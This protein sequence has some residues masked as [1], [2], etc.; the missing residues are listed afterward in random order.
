MVMLEAMSK[1][2][3]VVSFD[4]PTGP[5]EVIDHGEN[6]MLVPEGDVQALTGAMLE[7]I[8]DDEKRHRYGAAAA[9]TAATYAMSAVG[10][11]WDELLTSFAR[12]EPPEPQP[13][14]AAPA[15]A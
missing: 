12:P 11:E 14:H 1:G 3:P 4:C 6:G 10:P 9:A 7:L 5:R 2:L 8:E 15:R 13:S